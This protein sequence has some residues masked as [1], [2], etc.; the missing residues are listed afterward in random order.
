VKSVRVAVAEVVVEAAIVVA[1]AEEVV[2][3]VVVDETS[4]ERPICCNSY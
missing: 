2:T 4:T 3:Q 1:V